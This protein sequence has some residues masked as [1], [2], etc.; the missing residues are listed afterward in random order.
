MTDGYICTFSSP[1]MP[2]I[3]N[4][5]MTLMTPEEK[6]KELS[7]EFDFPVKLEIAKKASLEILVVTDSD[8][9]MYLEGDTELLAKLT[10]DILRK[11]KQD[12]IDELHESF[13]H[14]M[15]NAV[16]NNIND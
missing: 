9:E 6:A 10:P 1:S 7:R 13:C 4:I 8:V 15:T 2:G 16:A 14:A 11:I 3:F 12:L 5:S